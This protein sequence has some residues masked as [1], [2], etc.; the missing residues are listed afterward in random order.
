MTAPI[1]RPERTLTG[2]VTNSVTT[3]PTRLKNDRNASFDPRI[4]RKGQTRMD[5]FDDKV[6]SMYARGMSVREIRGHLKE[7]Y[8][9]EVSPDLVS[10][11]TGAVLE[12]VCA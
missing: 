6:I 4:V 11:V 2:T 5:G 12:E 7:L 1:P 9:I 10:R 3:P 8:G